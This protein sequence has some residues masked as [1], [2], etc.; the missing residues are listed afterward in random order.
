[1]IKTILQIRKKASAT[2]QAKSITSLQLLKHT[3]IV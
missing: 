2:F 3:E 1:M